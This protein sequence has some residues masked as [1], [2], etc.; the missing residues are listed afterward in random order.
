MVFEFISFKS[1]GID[2]KGRAVSEC[3]ILGPILVESPKTSAPPDPL[4]PAS[5][6]P[7]FSSH[8]THMEVTKWCIGAN[9]YISIFVGYIG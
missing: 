8:V 7:Y 6:N 9:S 2:V 5:F 4:T 3:M 1:L